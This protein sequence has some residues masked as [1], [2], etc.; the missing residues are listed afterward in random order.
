MEVENNPW[1][2]LSLEAYHFYFCP[3]CETKHETKDQFVGHAIV[4]HPRA[5]EF[6]P[7]RDL[8][9]LYGFDKN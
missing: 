3:E 5:R 8:A 1:N 6:I 4:K 7:R 9:L 2:V